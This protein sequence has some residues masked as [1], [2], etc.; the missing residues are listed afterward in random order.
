M[1]RRSIPSWTNARLKTQLEREP[2]PFP[3]L[4]FA[5]SREEIDNIDGFKYEDFVVEGYNPL[6]KIEMKMSA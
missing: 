1:N 2:R 6:G 5:R 4:K 3:T